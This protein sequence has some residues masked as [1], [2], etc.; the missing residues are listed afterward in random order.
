M[1]SYIHGTLSLYLIQISC[2]TGKGLGFPTESTGPEDCCISLLQF[3]QEHLHLAFEH[4]HHVLLHRFL[5]RT[6]EKITRFGK[7]AEQDYSLRR[8][9][10]SE[11]GKRLAKNISGVFEYLSGEPVTVDSRIIDIL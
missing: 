11:I 7:T 2:L 10:H 9:E 5:Q 1:T 6:H 8:G 3:G 4:V